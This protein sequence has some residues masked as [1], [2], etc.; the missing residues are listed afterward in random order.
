ME[1][2]KIDP[3]EICYSTEQIC[4]EMAEL[5]H[6]LETKR[7]DKNYVE[8]VLNDAE[9]KINSLLK[10][11]RNNE[12]IRLILRIAVLRCQMFGR[13]QEFE[14]VIDAANSAL[15]QI[16]GIHGELDE[17][18][19]FAFEAR[20]QGYKG[21]AFMEINFIDEAIASLRR[22]YELRTSGKKEVA[23][24]NC[25]HHKLKKNPKSNIENNGREAVK[26]EK[27]LAWC[28]A[29]KGIPAPAPPLTKFSRT[30]HL[31]N[32]GGTAVSTD[33]LVI[34][35]NDSLFIELGSG[36]K[37]VV[38]EEKVDGANFGISLAADGQIMTQN[39]SRYVS[40]GDH[41]QFRTITPWVEVHRE[42]LVKILKQDD[43]KRAAS[44]GLILFGEWVVARH[45]IA[46]DKLPGQFIAF[47]IYDRYYG[48]FFSRA[49]FHD[50]M[51]DSGIPVVP[52]IDIKRFGPFEKTR[53][54]KEQF[55]AELKL[56]LETPS[57]FITNGSPVEGVILRIDEEQ[58][59][60]SNRNTSTGPGKN[61]GWL[62]HR[63]KIVRPD[64]VA[65]CNGGHWSTRSLEK[66]II[67]FDFAS[68]Y[69]EDCYT[70]AYSEE[71]IPRKLEPKAVT[72]PIHLPDIEVDTNAAASGACEILEKDEST[73]SKSEKKIR[74][75]MLAAK[76]RLRKK[77]PKYVILMGLPAAGKSTFASALADEWQPGSGGNLK[78]IS[79]NRRDSQDEWVIVNQDKLGRLLTHVWE[80][81]STMY[82]IKQNVIN[83]CAVIISGKKACIDLASRSARRSRVVLDRCNPSESERREWLNI[84][85]NPP[86]SETAL[87][88]FASAAETCVDR[89][90]KRVGH[91]TIPEGRGERIVNDMAKRLEVPSDHEKKNVFG[92]VH[93][94][95]SWEDSTNILRRWGCS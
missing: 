82:V 59:S 94:V 69:L 36:N 3:S 20:I 73:L 14:L 29:L 48:R 2:L 95:H 30:A 50:A 37:D 90:K 44:K 60:H 46:Y 77:A 39:R 47:D 85:N 88:Y 79:S 76:A 17:D 75:E 12:L 84:L 62:E 92:T 25:S 27:A 49:R 93:I 51:K 86:K 91:E 66:Q 65:G 45:S 74:K 13:N 53:Q 7:L 52:V 8:E 5:L 71:D 4:D 72:S 58:S 89:A 35:N 40:S 28:C 43:R 68:K 32:A 9:C 67:D 33:D 6:T 42:A 22:S 55:E 57:R 61:S 1:S 64:F 31:F 38:V 81:Y 19:L 34:A 87:I 83:P 21:F 54:G 63:V 70:C 56:L 16:E 41:E 10:E 26:V 23:Q 18:T 78:G 24:V 15:K 11:E 80:I